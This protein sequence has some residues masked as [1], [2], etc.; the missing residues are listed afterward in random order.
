M[1]TLPAAPRRS[2]DELLSAEFMTRLEQLEILSRRIFVGRMKGERRSKRRGASVEF[3]DYRNY[4]PGDD[5]RFLDWN[6]FARLE[7]LLIKLFME[8]E[9]LNVTLLV[10]CSRSM[11]WGAPAKGMYA[12]RVAAAI[13]YIGL[14][15]YDR[16]SIYTYAGGLSREMVGIRGRRLASQ[17]LRFLQGAPLDGTSDF[18]SAARRFALRHKG[19]GVVIVISDFL[20]KGGYADGLRFLLS[21][22]LDLY[23]VQV[24]S[25]EEI[26]PTFAGDLKLRDVEDEDIAEITVSRPLLERYKANLTAF[27]TE[28]KDYCTRRG[29]TYLFTSTRVPFDTLV[30][31]YLRQRGLLR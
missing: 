30:M 14:V 31:S 6:I 15:N 29:V 3:A 12:K 24:L 8:E 5:L 21:R 27:C 23:V 4:V 1:P 20:D 11:D 26:D 10:D 17:M 2:D 9:D 16:V 22:E 28:L 7:R 13:G 19:K 18:A 25:P